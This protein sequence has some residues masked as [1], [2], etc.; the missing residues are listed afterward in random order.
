MGRQANRGGRVLQRRL[1]SGIAGAGD[2]RYVR[3]VGHKPHLAVVRAHRGSCPSTPPALGDRAG[4][5]AGQQVAGLLADHQPASLGN[6]TDDQANL[7][8]WTPR[9]IP[10]DPHHVGRTD[11]CPRV[12]LGELP[13]GEDEFSIR[14]H[15]VRVASL[16]VEGV[17]G[18][19]PLD[20]D[21]LVGVGP[22]EEQA[23]GE[24]PLRGAVRGVEH[25]VVPDGNHAAGLLRL[26]VP[27]RPKRESTHRRKRGEV[28]RGTAGDHRQASRGGNQE[29]TANGACHGTP[30]HLHFSPVLNVSDRSRNRAPRIAFL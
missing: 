12:V 8:L 16:F 4:A 1:S 7:L 26:A 14:F 19:G 10:R 25:R 5:R 15:L 30:F 21:R 27:A 2:W 18:Q 28:P 29:T 3:L 24:A 11:L 9:L 13:R 6:E 22:V 23:A 20:L 17:D